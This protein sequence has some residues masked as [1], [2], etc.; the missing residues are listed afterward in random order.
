MSIK[1]RTTKGNAFESMIWRDGIS[2]QDFYC[3]GREPSRILGL[4]TH[5]ELAMREPI[6]NFN[7]PKSLSSPDFLPC[8]KKQEPLKATRLS[9]TRSAFLSGG[10]SCC[11]WEINRDGLGWH[12][13][14]RLNYP[15]GWVW[16]K[17]V[18]GGGNCGEWWDWSQTV[19]CLGSHIGRPLRSHQSSHNPTSRAFSLTNTY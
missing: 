18:C 7:Y 5:L 3:I 17:W 14:S 19:Y 15:A 10:I 8:H 6:Q 16:W 13:V 12:V 1:W 2:P 9:L 11:Y 4:K